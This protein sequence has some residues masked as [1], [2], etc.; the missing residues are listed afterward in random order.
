MVSTSGRGSLTTTA[1]PCARKSAVHDAP[2]T[3]APTTV[4]F[5]YRFRISCWAV[6]IASALLLLRTGRRR[7]VSE[8]IVDD[9]GRRKREIRQ[10]VRSRNDLTDGKICKRRQHVLEQLQPRRPPPRA[11]HGDIGDLG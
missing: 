4:T 6:A 7:A 8:I 9:R 1:S 10:D 2:M 3:P 11:L 5:E